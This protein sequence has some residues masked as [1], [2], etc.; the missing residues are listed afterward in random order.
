MSISKNFLTV[1]ILT[2][3]IATTQDLQSS[4]TARLFGP[5]ERAQ[6][7]STAGISMVS[8]KNS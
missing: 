4:I 3:S 2:A 8:T 1:I 6:F 5:F 7:G